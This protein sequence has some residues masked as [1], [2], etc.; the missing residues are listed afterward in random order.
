MPDWFYCTVSRPLLFLLPAKTA[1][2]VTLSAMG[3]LSR[4]PL[5]EQLIS[6]LGHMDPDPRLKQVRD[7]I[8]FS[9]PVGLSAWLDDEG[10]AIGAFKRFGAGFIE[11]GPIGVLPSNGCR[12][13]RDAIRRA[14]GKSAETVLNAT[15]ARQRVNLAGHAPVI[16]WLAYDSEISQT[17]LA[18]AA[19]VSAFSVAFPANQTEMGQLGD[20]LQI[21][22]KLMRPV[23]LRVSMDTNLDDAANAVKEMG[24]A[25]AFV[26]GRSWGK[27]DLRFT[28]EYAHEQICLQ[29]KVLR[30][31]F[32]KDKTIIASGGIHSPAQ[33]NACLQAGATLL[34][35]DS[36]L[37]YAGPGL[38]KRINESLLADMPEPLDHDVADERTPSFLRR[39]WFWMFLMGLGLS[40]G[41]ILAF[42]IALTSVIL[43]YDEAYIGLTRLQLEGINPHVIGFLTHDRVTL[44]GTMLSC[45][46]LYMMLAWNAVRLGSHPAWVAIT[47]SALSGFAG[48]FLFLGFGYLDPL[49]AFAATILFQFLA[50]GLFAKLGIAK[51]VPAL[52]FCND[53]ARILGLWG[54]FLFILQGAALI[55]AGL[56]I[57][58]IGATFVF[59]PQDLAFLQNTPAGLAH[60][61]NPKI[62]SLIAH[63]RATMGA[64]L[65]ANGWLYLL[66]PLWMFRT[67]AR[68]QWVSLALAGFIG[69]G[70]AI[71]IHVDVSYLDIFHLAPAFAGLALHC[72]ALALSLPFLHQKSKDA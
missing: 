58:G 31:A 62:I 20:V 39:S 7:G 40:I 63:D 47:L 56:V 30:T 29:I 10:Q 36:G 52:D 70:A 15:T 33:A 43:P 25:G 38:I 9:S 12:V 59:V 71:A 28:G 34:A 24:L 6:F 60:A 37:V 26:D 67:G 61:I 5:G 32:G 16:A 23:Y 1:R 55:L 27:N 41:G 57:S 72:V 21:V 50:L 65:V 53:T 68:W 66:V 18:L 13:E 35:L 11:I 2:D 46:L 69:Y 54:Q 14:I 49:H 17:A 19:R 51:H 44:A 3:S 4:L 8:S 42:G 45:G 64:M 22:Q 48:F